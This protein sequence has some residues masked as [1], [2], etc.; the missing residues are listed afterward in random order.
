MDVIHA[1]RV[2]AD[3]ATATPTVGMFPLL[4]TVLNRDDS[5]GGGTII[6]IKDC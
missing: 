1:Q 2:I 3:A 6:P 5:K 4:L